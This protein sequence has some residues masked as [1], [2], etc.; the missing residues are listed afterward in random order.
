MGFCKTILYDEGC[1][2]SYVATL[3]FREMIALCQ[4]GKNGCLQDLMKEAQQNQTSAV[5]ETRFFSFL[6]SF[7]NT[8]DVLASSRGNV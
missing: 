5:F 2:D 4:T 3:V 1:D 8:K 7:C 6:S